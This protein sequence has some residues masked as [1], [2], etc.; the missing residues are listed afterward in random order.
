MKLNNIKRIS[1][2]EKGNIYTGLSIISV[3]SFILAIILILNF[4]IANNESKINIKDSNNFNYI[5]EDYKRNIP[6]IGREIIENLS[7]KSIKNHIPCDNSKNTI[8]DQ[9]NDRLKEYNLRYKKNNDVN[10]ENE[11]LS[12]FN[13]ENPYHINL[14]TQIIMKKDKIEYNNMIESVISIEG[15]KDPLPFLMCRDYQ[16]ISE[17]GSK[18]NYN[19]ALSEYMRSNDLLNPEIYENATGS[20]IIKKC[21]YDPYEQHGKGNCM[22]NCVDNGYFHESAD[23]SCY[24]CRLEG[25]GSCP[26]YGLEVFIIP[27]PKETVNLSSISGSDHVIYKDHYYGKGVAFYKKNN[28]FEVIIIDD[29]HGA[30]Y[31]MI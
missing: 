4:T 16:N 31:G 19:N 11:V 9:L 2:C 21:V 7:N 14:K 27:S 29:S 23:G 12:V 20:L 30:K 3:F 24:L 28:L 26:H 10:I 18:I 22:K 5:I 6:I 1:I 25:K 15:L 13:G 17:N 8:Q